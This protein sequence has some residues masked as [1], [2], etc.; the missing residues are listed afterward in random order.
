MQLIWGAMDI[1]EQI[2][3]DYQQFPKHQSYHLYADDV[4]FKDPLNEFRGI[5]RYRSMIGFI[6]KWFRD[7][8]LELHN[9]SYAAPQEI[10][11]RWTLN[12]VAPLP[13]QPK[14]SIPGWSQLKLGEDGKI[15]SHTDYWNCSRLDVVKQLF[16]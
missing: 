16:S 1:L 6:D 12:W 2:R 13:W 5:E 8:H 4:F 3:T 10:E 15:I 11:T 7:V 9:I 14:M